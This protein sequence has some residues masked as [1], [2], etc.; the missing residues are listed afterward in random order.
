M[1]D[2]N[3]Q[4]MP[5]GEN[6]W[7][8]ILEASLALP[9]AKVNRKSFLESQLRPTVVNQKSVRQFNIGLPWRAF[10]LS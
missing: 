2:S 8:R 4:E 6:L 9:G 10:R 3:T 7:D 1:A 5:N